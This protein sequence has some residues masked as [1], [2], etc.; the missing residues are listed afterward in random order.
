MRGNSKGS[1]LSLPDSD[2]EVEDRPLHDL[3]EVCLREALEAELD[4]RNDAFAQVVQRFTVLFGNPLNRE[5]IVQYI[6][7]IGLELGLSA[8]E[9]EKAVQDRLFE[10]AYRFGYWDG[11]ASVESAEFPTEGGVLANLQKTVSETFSPSP[12]QESK[13]PAKF[14]NRRGWGR[15]SRWE[16]R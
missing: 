4:E 1:D 3:A 14:F 12:T 5:I 15:R 16:E 6:I 7:P 8:E 2:L 10:A 13:V 11:R 9:C